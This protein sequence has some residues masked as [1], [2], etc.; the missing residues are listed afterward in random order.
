MDARLPGVVLALGAAVCYGA[1][2]ALQAAEVRAVGGAVAGPGA[3]IRRLLSRPRW[4]AGAA[5]GLFGWPLQEAALL[6]AP[7]AVVEAC[8]AFGPV[9]L[10]AL[11]PRRLHER[12]GGAE[13]AAAGLLVVGVAALAFAVPDRSDS[14]AGVG[15][16]LPVLA[17]LGLVAILPFLWRR[18][19]SRYGILVAVCAGASFAASDLATKLLS[20]DVSGHVWAGGVVWL[21]IVG[22]MSALGVTNEMV[23]YRLAPASRAAPIAFALEIGVPI[24]LAP[25][26]TGDRVTRTGLALAGGI[27]LLAAVALLAAR[28][29]WGRVVEAGAQ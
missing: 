1:A 16:L 6:F 8:L 27:A 18:A 20:D 25:L 3:L 21:A 2:V 9:V 7:L 24:V 23:S 5:L 12:V 19:Q 15:R 11:A 17:A 29:S 28:S 4:L 10:L 26:L 14:H 13:I 22:A